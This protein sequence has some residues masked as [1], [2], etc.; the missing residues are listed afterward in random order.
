MMR[1]WLAQA[2]D[3]RLPHWVLAGLAANLCWLFI[4]VDWRAARP[5][6]PGIRAL[7]LLSISTCWIPCAIA[8]ALLVGTW[9]GVT[10]KR[11]VS[12]ALCLIVVLLRSELGEHLEYWVIQ[13]AFACALTFLFHQDGRPTPDCSHPMIRWIRLCTGLA[14][15]IVFRQSF[16]A[17][18]SIQTMQ[19]H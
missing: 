14:L 1:R 4:R 3:L 6:L 10:D 8:L 12:V 11:S 17:L 16:P 7:L 19:R 2:L 9:R 18:L 13:I 15:P 5:Y